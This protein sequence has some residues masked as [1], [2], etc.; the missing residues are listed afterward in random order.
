[1]E[2][3]SQFAQR[4]VQG[5]QPVDVPLVGGVGLVRLGVGVGDR[6]GQV[7]DGPVRAGGGCDDA[8]HVKLSAEPQHMRRLSPRVG[9]GKVAGLFPGGQD[10]A[11]V[12]VAVIGTIPDR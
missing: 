4:G 5:S 10:F 11:G 6:L 2:K 12:G 9:I 1:M 7:P 8:G 3:R